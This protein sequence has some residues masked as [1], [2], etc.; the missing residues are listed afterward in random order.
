MAEHSKEPWSVAFKGSISCAVVC[1]KTVNEAGGATD[2]AYYGGE[3]VAESV[4]R[5]DATRIVACVNA[6]AGI[7]AE[8]LASSEA[9]REHLAAIAAIEW[10]ARNPPTEIAK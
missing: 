2:V 8:A 10:R 1:D 5:A 6:C 9:L 3:L 7:P 4:C